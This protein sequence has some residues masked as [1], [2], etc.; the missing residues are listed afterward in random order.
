MVAW[1]HFLY[2]EGSTLRR[3]RP[4]MSICVV[5]LLSGGCC[6]FQKTI[7]EE[8]GAEKGLSPLDYHARIM[9]FFSHGKQLNFLSTRSDEYCG[10]V[11]AAI[12]F[13]T[14]PFSYSRLDDRVNADTFHVFP[15][16]LQIP[17]RLSYLFS[18][19]QH[20]MNVVNFDW[21]K[22]NVICIEQPWI[23]SSFG[24]RS[25]ELQLILP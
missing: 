12:G 23:C 1:T 13:G 10:N 3:I 20:L 19:L 8:E 15:Q 21:F 6:D 2:F 14:G 9:D 25:P 22:R 11:V 16:N 7:Y 17:M 5:V 18:N 24:P 4:V